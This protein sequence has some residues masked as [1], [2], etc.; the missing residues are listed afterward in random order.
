MTNKKPTEEQIVEALERF[1][2]NASAV[3]REFGVPART[4]RRWVAEGNLNVPTS[5][6]RKVTD[7]QSVDGSLSPESLHISTEELMKKY[8]LGDDYVP[9]KLDVSER[10]AGTATAPKVNRSIS[11]S[12]EKKVEL[13]KPAFGGR[14]IVVKPPKRRKTN[15]RN[16]E[17]VVILSDYHAPYVDWDLHQASLRH[18]QEVQPDRIIVNGDLVDFPTVGRHRKT[19]PHGQATASECIQAGGK[20]LADLKAA[21]SDDCRIQFIAGNHDAWLSNYILNQAGELYELKA[22]NDDNV[23][24]S[25]KNLFRLDELGIE[26]VGDTYDYP[27]TF[28]PLTNHLIVHHGDVARKNSGASA[29]GSMNNKDYAEI[30]GH[31]H[32]Q[33]VISKTIWVMDPKTGQ[34]VPRIYQGGECGT[35]CKFA[36]PADQFPTYTRLPDWAGGYLSVEIDPSGFYSIDLATWQGDKLLW[37]GKEW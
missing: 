26:I 17:L 3:A 28:V 4:M 32:R 16:S 36:S 2:G 35:M 12:V 34:Q 13:P 24:W 19:T 5:K 9:V 23:V 21:A 6:K 10:D 25:F 1:N 31:V 33:S 18:I 20:I 22:Y 27:H 7:Q 37:R 8:N 29:I 15:K 11:L 14:P 30:I